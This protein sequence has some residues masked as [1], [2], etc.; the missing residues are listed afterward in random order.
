MYALNGGLFGERSK[1][2]MIKTQRVTTIKLR[3]RHT[4]EVLRKE[5]N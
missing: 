4:K 3:S 1:G 5:K 2:A